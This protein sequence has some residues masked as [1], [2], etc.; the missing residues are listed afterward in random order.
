MYN[1]FSTWKVRMRWKNQTLLRERRRHHHVVDRR[2]TEWIT[3]DP[4]ASLKNVTEGVELEG[5]IDS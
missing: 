2:G 5:N 3:W 1:T 4:V